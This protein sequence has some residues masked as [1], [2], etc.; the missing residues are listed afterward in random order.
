MKLV[1]RIISMKPT[2]SSKEGQKIAFGDKLG[3][4]FGGVF[5]DRFRDGFVDAFGDGFEVTF[6]DEFGNRL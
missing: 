1:R 5:G 3:D 6:G 4:G 2:I